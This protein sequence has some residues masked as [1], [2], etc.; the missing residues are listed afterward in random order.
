MISQV[1]DHKRE[2]QFSVELLLV[3]DSRKMRNA[4]I[5][6][7]AFALI[8]TAFASDDALAEEFSPGIVVNLSSGF[9]PS[10]ITLASIAK[11]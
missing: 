1:T 10:I 3:S 8:A 5:I 11:S 6:L 4:T 9:G 2:S 7:I